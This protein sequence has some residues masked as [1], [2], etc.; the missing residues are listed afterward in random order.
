M[1]K[2]QFPLSG[3]SGPK[4][5]HKPVQAQPWPQECKQETSRGW[6]ILFINQKT[7]PSRKNQ[8]WELFSFLEY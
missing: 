8:E 6:Y 3:P 7:R 1:Q 5:V 2:P 4:P